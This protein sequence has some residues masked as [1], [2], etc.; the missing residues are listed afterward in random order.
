MMFR[1]MYGPGLFGMGGFFMWFIWICIVVLFIVGLSYVVSRAFNSN[2]VNERHKEYDDEAM[3]VLMKRYANGE[4]D[5][6]EFERIKK[7]LLGA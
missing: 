7:D 2:S 6:E 1:G 5:R 3:R 4:I